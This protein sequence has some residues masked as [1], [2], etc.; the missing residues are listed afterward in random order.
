MQLI[1]LIN[2]PQNKVFQ[3][4]LTILGQMV[5]SDLVRQIQFLKVEN[6]IIR[7][8]I[9]K[10]V[11]RTTYQEKL[12]LI[13]FGLPLNGSIKKIISIVNYSTFRRWINALE[14]GKLKKNVK[15]GRPRRTAQDIINLI[16]RMAEKISIGDMVG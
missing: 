4:F 8:K 1:N 12:R 15:L 2:T 11:I 14:E 3:Y 16:V 5:H 6:E 10:Q 7:S 13:R 9:D